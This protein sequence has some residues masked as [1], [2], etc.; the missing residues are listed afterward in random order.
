M[1]DMGVRAHIITVEPQIQSK[2][3]KQLLQNVSDFFCGGILPCTIQE[4]LN[5]LWKVFKKEEWMHHF[6]PIFKILAGLNW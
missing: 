4:L 2:F 3:K 6:A 1:L 5:S